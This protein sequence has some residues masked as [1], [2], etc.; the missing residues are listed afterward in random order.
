MNWLNN[1]IN[2]TFG[3]VGIIVL[4]AICANVL[5]LV[6]SE[7]HAQHVTRAR[8]CESTAVSAS[9]LIRRNDFV[10]LRA[11]LR[12]MTER[13]Q[14]VQSIGLRTADDRLIA[15][16]NNHA[17]HWARPVQSKWERQIIP[18]Q[19][20]TSEVDWGDLEFTF[21]PVSSENAGLIAGLTPTTRLL[22]FVCAMTG[23]LTMIYLGAMLKQLEPSKSVPTQ[24]RGALDTLTEGL[25]VLNVNGDIA[26]AN[27]VFLSDTQSDLEQIIN[28]NPKKA[29][30]WRDSNGE[31][32]TEYPWDAS[33]ETGEHVM[34]RIMTLRVPKM[35]AVQAD[36]D[37]DQP[38]DDT[39][40]FRVN[41][42]PVLARSSKGN[43][44]L[45]S[46]ENVTELENSK[47]AAECAN[48]AKSD[49]LAN[50]SHEIR[51][52]M[53]AILGFTD[54]LRRGL[55]K[56]EDEKQEYL[57]TIHSS[58]K[59]LMELIN[60]IL[61]LSKIEAGKMEMNCE[62][63]CPFMIVAD[64]TN[65]LRVRSD[66]KGIGLVT[67]FQSKL[68][69][70]ICTDDV[71]LRQVIT[72][73]LGN[74]IKFT[75]EGEVRVEVLLDESDHVP[76]LEVSIVDSG[77][78]M[79]PEQLDKIFKP[80]VQADSSVTRN[81]GGTGLGLAISK[82]IVEA[83]GGSIEVHSELG[84][85]SRFTFRVQTGDIADIPRL[86]HDEFLASRKQ[87]RGNQAQGVL[88][89]PPGNVL[90][91]DDGQANRRLIKLILTK[92]GCDVTEAENGQEGL[93]AALNGTFDVVLMDMQMPVLDGY[94]AT[95]KLRENGYTGTIVALT[96]NAMSG[97]QEKCF[98]AGC[99][100]FVA[101][102]VD[103]DKLLETIAPYMCPQ[104]DATGTKPQTTV[105]ASTSEPAK[106]PSKE[107]EKPGSVIQQN[108]NGNDSN[109]GFCTIFQE[110]LVLFQDNWNRN[111]LLQVG[112][113][114]KNLSD[115]AREF[116][117]DQLATICDTLARVIDAE[118]D[119]PTEV[120]TAFT[121]LLIHAK[122][123][124]T[125]D[126]WNRCPDQEE[127]NMPPE[128]SDTETT[129]EP[130][131]DWIY[132]NLPDDPEFAIIIVDFVPVLESKL[133]EMKLALA[134]NDFKKL[135]ELGHWLKGAGGTCGFKEFFDPALSLEQAAKTQNADKVADS[136]ATLVDLKDRVWVPDVDPSE[137]E[138]DFFAPGTDET[139]S[140]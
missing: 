138:T 35:Q 32:V 77:I 44:V 94:Q 137:I 79:T 109:N 119:D 118:P 127:T 87:K 55:A 78:G 33:A 112:A 113:T 51:T 122:D 30:Q 114:A 74:A 116:G 34:G 73:L 38:S 67:E 111:N 31:L 126:R 120:E 132:S 136:L 57:S 59:H 88:S 123:N 49:F 13:C 25:L 20:D 97:D 26:L 43:G 3:L 27:K 121:K 45:V 23:L 61:D 76:F 29:F 134:D 48:Q 110:H 83:L 40:I 131:K 68:P 17:E 129:P 98:A 128:S 12:Q 66:D 2:L 18:L 64:V 63:R 91:V 47:K 101:K 46:F 84:K 81:F 115:E 80:F 107:G 42:A 24:V 62:P 135:A 69:E 53:N 56:S 5:G 106:Q 89:L 58:G 4:T 85:G 102:P 82:K 21:V 15:A 7:E 92:A 28:Q 70:T 6:P 60:D 50:M 9:M 54:W 19:T 96:A 117:L 108:Q 100:D 99:D 86:T 90:V 139:C 14:T 130:S 140:V 41:C 71:R 22:T 124:M 65:I 95:T 39:L 133:T 52:P 8:L 105:H 103:I 72:N 16:T 10:A 37:A 125:T 104:S 93:E 75:S 11:L 1:R 36:D